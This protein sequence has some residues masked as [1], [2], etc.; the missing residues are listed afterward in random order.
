L[1]IDKAFVPQRPDLYH[2][3]R[4]LRGEEQNRGMWQTQLMTFV[5]DFYKLKGIRP[6]MVTD[7][8]PSDL[9]CF[10]KLAAERTALPN[11]I[12]SPSEPVSYPLYAELSETVM[13]ARKQ[14]E[15]GMP[16]VLYGVKRSESASCLP[17]HLLVKLSI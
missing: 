14:S 3:E 5:L 13:T 12:W 8:A 6:L 15:N 16:P 10:L 9:L 1:F 2:I 4:I 17:N 11:L 7:C